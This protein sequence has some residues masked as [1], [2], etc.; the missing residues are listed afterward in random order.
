MRVLPV[1]EGDVR[2]GGSWSAMQ[3]TKNTAIWLLA[4]AALAAARPLPPS[5]LRAIGR[6][7]GLAAHRLAGRARRT[8]LDNVSLALPHLDDRERRDLVERCFATLGTLL[9]ETVAMM[10]PGA[11]DPL[12]FAPGALATFDGARAAGRGVLFVSAHL[13]PWERV[14]ASLVAAGIP[15]VAIA[16]E[17]YDPRLSR[18]YERLR[19]RHG[20]DVIW[21]SRPGASARILRALRGGRV[22]GVPMDLRSRVSSCDAPF[23]GHP[24]PTPVGPARIALRTRSPV[25]VGTVAP[26]ALGALQVTVSR[27]ETSDVPADAHGAIELTRRINLELSSRILALPHAWV[28]MHDRWPSLARHG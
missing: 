23:L 17:S 11:I 4:S 24:A 28:W 25:L 8:A 10:R 21:R 22:L 19:G 12:P 3:R 14:A 13:G 27:I 20:V 6:G 9:G 7:L 2:E 26:D 18:I 5:V 15:L 16:R 1:N